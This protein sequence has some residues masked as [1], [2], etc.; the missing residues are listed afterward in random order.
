[1]AKHTIAI[2]FDFDDT[3]VPDS[4]TTLLASRGI[5]TRKFWK[6]DAS[7][8]VKKGW[9]PVNAFLKLF[10]DLTL[11]D[12]PLANFTNK[13][14]RE[15]GSTLELY[16]GLPEF[17]TNLKSWFEDKFPDLD[18]GIEYFVISGGFEEIIRGCESISQHLKAYW[19]CR[20]EPE[21][22]NGPVKYIKRSISFTE[23]TRYLFE[24]NKGLRKNATDKNP[25]LVNKEVTTRAIPFKN[26]IYIGDG[27]TDIPCLSLVK[28]YGGGVYGIMHQEKIAK[29]RADKRRAFQDFLESDRTFGD[30]YPIYD[31]D[32]QLAGK[33]KVTL[34]KIYST[35]RLREAGAIE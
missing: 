24:I 5:D 28:H 23:K 17:F 18:I 4:T 25:F 10:L 33:I 30:Y 14:L 29:I 34:G 21:K 15:F 6:Q 32:N 19:G 16:P 9:D 31:M 22:R 27:Y 1:M 3:L 12:Q 11:P 20:L 26:M 35:I 2:I 13:D 8:L 7:D